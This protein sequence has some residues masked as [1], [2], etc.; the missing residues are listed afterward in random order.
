MDDAEF[1]RRLSEVA[2]W[3]I[4]D[5]PRET[6]LNQKK[7]RGRK[8]NEDINSDEDDDYSDESL[9]YRA[10]LENNKT[11]PPMLTKVHVQGI[12]CPDC[13]QYCEKGHKKEATLYEKNG[14]RAWRQQCMICRKFENPYTGEFNL[15]GPAASIKFNDFMRG[16][17]GVYKTKANNRRSKA[18]PKENNKPMQTQISSVKKTLEDDRSIITFY[19]FSADKK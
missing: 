16:S 7:K 1:K 4:P 2:E 17:K 6:S 11:Y 9:V 15:T 5:T 18:T 12:N 19:Q 13:G 14:C 3:K 8:I 10:H